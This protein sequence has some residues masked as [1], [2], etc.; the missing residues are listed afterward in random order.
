[1]L[2]QCV[3]MGQL[4]CCTVENTFKKHVK[5]CKLTHKNKMITCS[6]LLWLFMM[7]LHYDFQIK[8]LST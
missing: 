1:M 5:S 6:I 3:M 4:S 8:L 2:S 7:H